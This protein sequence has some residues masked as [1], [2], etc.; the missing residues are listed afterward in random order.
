M[1]L[2]NLTQNGNKP[3][4]GRRENE[5]EIESRRGRLRRDRGRSIR[6]DSLG[7][8][9]TRVK[10][11]FDNSVGIGVV[12][13]AARPSDGSACG[14]PHAEERAAMWRGKP[15]PFDWEWHRRV[16]DMNKELFNNLSIGAGIKKSRLFIC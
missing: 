16:Y 3:A 12:E 15:P 13:S 8:L 9:E 2:T 4:T 11:G 6:D 10:E 5:N 14:G 1:H 7:H